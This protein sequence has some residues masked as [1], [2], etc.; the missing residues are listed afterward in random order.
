MGPMAEWPVGRV[1]PA[2]R[3]DDERPRRSDRVDSSR[4]E[5]LLKLAK[6]AAYTA[7]VIVSM[8]TPESVLAQSSVSHK[9]GG[10]SKGKG[11]NPNAVTDFSA[12]P[13]ASPGPSA[14][15]Q[16]APPGSASPPGGE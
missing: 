9:K 8:A 6:G 1:A 3:G 13:A 2:R 5:F 15:W 14:P 4:R 12:G 16:V 11:K 10:G 7:P